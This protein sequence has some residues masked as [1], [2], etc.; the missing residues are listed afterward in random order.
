MK[1]HSAAFVGFGQSRVYRHDDE[2][3]GLLAGE[4]CRTAI[5]DAGLDAS[6]IDGVA[7]VPHPPFLIEDL[8]QDGVHHVS[9][10]Y[11]ARALGL[12]VTWSAEL[13]VQVGHAAVAAVNAV[14]AGLCRYAL[15]FRALHSPA[16]AY[17]HNHQS[18][19][20]GVE[21]FVAPY[22]QFYPA[23]VGGQAWTRYQQKYGSGS[24]E[25]MAT[26]VV[27]SRHNGLKFPDGYWARFKPQELTVADYLSTRM[28]ATPLC[29]LDCDLPVQGAGAF[30]V[31]SAERAEDLR[32][33]P[34]YVHGVA[35]SRG[36]EI[37][38]PLGSFIIENQI[39]MA[40]RVLDDLWRDS[41]LTVADVRVADLYDGFSTLTIAWL[42][43]M[44]VCGEGE[45]FEF[46]QDG[47][48]AIDGS[49]PINPSGGS[50]GTGRLHGVNHLMDAIL[51][52]MGRSGPRQVANA[53]I[54]LAA[55][56]TP[57]L[58]ALLLLGR[59]PAVN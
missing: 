39:A 37:G 2:P 27:Q 40:K 53:D 32:H 33:P 49:L 5:S 3:L 8:Q 17:G 43:G 42:E 46:I 29:V 55:I 11:I 38:A 22:G 4:A 58:A 47:R 30:I 10:G 44:G 12:N 31:T 51:Q 59:E 21:Q 14:E 25:Q 13:D 18:E 6:D 24:R 48:I 20:R 54:T 45:A 15:V 52:V 19:A 16:G 41:G 35:V 56:G 1:R 7:C 9:A 50:L 28:V 57:R 36:K 23:Q 34:A 26:L